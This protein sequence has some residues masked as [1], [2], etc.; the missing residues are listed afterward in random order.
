MF[1]PEHLKKKDPLSTISAINSYYLFNIYHM[2][3]GMNNTPL[4]H[5]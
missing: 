2:H 5:I 3:A 4:V 1:G